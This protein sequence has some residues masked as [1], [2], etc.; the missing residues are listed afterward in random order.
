MNKLYYSAP[1]A[2]WNE[3]LPLGNGRLGAMVFGGAT[4]ERIQLNE[5]SLWSGG[6]EDRVNPS[7]REYM[8]RLRELIAQGRIGEAEKLA[9]RAFAAAADDERHYEP[10]A[11]LVLYFTE[12]SPA[13]SLHAVRNLAKK[14]LS[15]CFPAE[16]ENYARSLDLATGLHQVSYS[17]RGAEFRRETFVSAPDQ[18]LCLR[19]SGRPYDVLLRRG[20]QVGRMYAADG[21][22]VV[23]CGCAANGGVSYACAVRVIRGEVKLIG[24]TLCCGGDN[25]IL[26]AGATGYDHE[27]PV[28][29]ALDMLDKAEQKGYEALR[30]AHAADLSAVMDRCALEIKADPALEALPTDQRLER[31]KQGE[32]DA[33]LINVYFQYGRYLLACSSRPGTLPAN[34]QGIWNQ[35]FEPPWGSKYTININTQMN[36]WPAEIC[37]L[38]EMHLPLFD[39]LKRM[40]PHGRKVARDMYGASG[41]VAHHNTDIWGDC[42]P[43]DSYIASTVW[44]MGAAWL[45]L[46]IPVHYEYTLD[47]NFLREYYPLMKES[48][49]FFADTLTE[50]RDGYLGVSPSCSPENTYILSDGEQGRLCGD[51]AMDAQILRELF[52]AVIKYGHELGEDV[53]AFEA[54]L[55]RLR[56]VQ[57]SP[58]GTIMEWGQDYGEAEIGHRHI[59]HLFALHPGS[60]ITP[61]QAD[62]FAAAHAT[63]ERRLSH[64]GGHTGWSRAWIINFYARLLDGDSCRQHLNALLS[65][66]TLPNLL[67][68]HPPFQIDG[69]FGA[70]AAIAQMLLQ[71]HEGKI[72][73][74]PALPG[75]WQE[76]CVRGLR[77]R[78]GYQADIRWA[79]GRLEEAVFTAG[80]EGELQLTDGRSIRHRKGDRIRVTA[81][82]LELI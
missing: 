40:L 78:G 10:L 77:A 36:Y 55:P 59:S 53:S 80:T 23:L 54:I 47:R 45:C 4:L 42:A 66:S 21:R 37:N 73:L 44:Q 39:H 15:G 18:V 41:W 13:V 68:N 6:F 43:Q 31:V 7:A 71:S 64:G 2:S 74:L 52:T 1:A 48:A 49:A 19:T 58:R 62:V 60:Q 5:E 67:D 76:G 75:E 57:I 27:D 32:T 28:Q 79:G 26:C 61:G 38:P 65:R 20:S 29:A 12:D 24:A 16:T 33:G 69:N 22:T 25:D 35:E 81:D 63:L 30:E 11:D 34:L 46:H 72:R 70:T 8:P 51:A 56:T 3:A 82:T 14:D 9:L 17:L 50:D